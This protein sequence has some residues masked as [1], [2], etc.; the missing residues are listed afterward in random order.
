MIVKIIGT[1]PDPGGLVRYAFGHG[2]GNEHTRQ[3]GGRSVGVRAYLAPVL[4]ETARP[5]SPLE[6]RLGF[7]ILRHGVD[8]VGPGCTRRRTVSPTRTAPAVLPGW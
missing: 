6:H 7:R 3:R 4:F 2:Q 5:G 8:G 1:G